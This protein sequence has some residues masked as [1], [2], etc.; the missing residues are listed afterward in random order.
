[1]TME[2]F[3]VIGIGNFGSFVAQRLH[4]LGHDVIAIDSRQEVVEHIGPHVARAVV[5]D[6]TDREVLDELGVRDSSAAIVS[7]GDNLA[8]SVLALLALRDLGLQDIYVKVISEE[9]RRIVDALGATESVF[10]ERQAGEALATRLTSRRLLR[11]VE[12]H[13]D[14]SLQEMAV[15]DEWT[16]KTLRELSL[17]AQFSVQIVA[18]HDVLRDVI[19]TPPDPDRKL[20][21]SDTLLVAGK[22][23]SLRELAKL[24]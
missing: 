7:T 14:L 13:E 8:A 1:M 2:R 17:P 3:T 20:T 4:Q 18:L 21:P 5:A 24:T 9:H 23:E 6:G 11:Y 15:P 19:A 16:G 10:P 12:V 22:P